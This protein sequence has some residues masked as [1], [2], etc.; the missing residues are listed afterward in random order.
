MSGIFVSNKFII[1]PARCNHRGCRFFKDAERPYQACP[2]H[3]FCSANRFAHSGLTNGSLRR[4]WR[5]CAPS[6]GTTL[7]GWNGQRP[8]SS[9]IPSSDSLPG[10]RCVRNSS[11]GPSPS[12]RSQT[13]SG[14]RK[15]TSRVVAMAHFR[16]KPDYASPFTTECHPMHAARSTLAQNGR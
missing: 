3:W 5:S 12:R 10:S 8:I 4:S 2:A 15:K 6:T 16:P 13:L 14:S 9:L 7:A 1:H 11:F